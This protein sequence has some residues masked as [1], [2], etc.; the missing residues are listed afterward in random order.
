MTDHSGR[1][2]EILSLSPV[3]PVLTFADAA[4][5]VAVGGALIEGGL[6]VLEVTLRT[7]A[8]VD[9]V[10]ALAKA[11]PNATIGAGTVLDTI[12]ARAAKAAGA[13]FLV[14][15]GVTE[16]LLR[17][18]EG[19]SLP[20]LFGAAGAADIMR[21]REYGHRVLKFF[22]A[23][24]AGGVAAM[25]AFAPVFADVAFCPTGGIDRALAPNYLEL[26]N[27]VAVGGSWVA[28]AD[29]V[30]SGDLARIAALAREAAALPRTGV[31]AR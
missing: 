14:S 7:E 22:P 6:A 15:P 1:L 5:A 11:F 21:L 3:I 16:R 9:C 12:R 25:R 2:R 13:K 8:G 19:F 24:T 18:A 28:P 17:D 20:W 10:A 30:A 4:Q 27:V 29:A 26:A 23:E 31:A